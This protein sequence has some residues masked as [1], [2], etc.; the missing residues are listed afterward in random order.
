MSNEKKI[1]DLIYS[2]SSLIKEAEQ[3]SKLLLEI[4]NKIES[5]DLK[6][7]NMLNN[8]KIGFSDDKKID[9]KKIK[10]SQPA[11]KSKYHDW[12]L[13]SFVK[14]KHNEELRVNFEQ[15]FYKVFESEI[16]N[17]MK[18]NFKDLVQAE[19]NKFSSRIIA[20]KLK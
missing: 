8:K 16:N 14:E 3:E 20:E 11:E 5:F 19:L 7:E 2:I 1:E 12:R 9:D 6:K 15:R 13:L 4:E 10:D 17:W 18:S